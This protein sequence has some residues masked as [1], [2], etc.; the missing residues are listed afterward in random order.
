MSGKFLQGVADHFSIV[1][2]FAGVSCRRFIAMR[3]K[4]NLVTYVQRPLV[5]DRRDGPER[6]LNEKT[7]DS[8]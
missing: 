1:I 4:F 3:Y 2:G 5:I 6:N 7:A 8:R